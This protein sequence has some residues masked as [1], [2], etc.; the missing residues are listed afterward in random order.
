LPAVATAVRGRDDLGRLG[1]PGKETTRLRKKPVETVVTVTMK[2]TVPREFP[3]QPS[4]DS[5]P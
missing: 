4:Q 2:V 5:R 1:K 3:A